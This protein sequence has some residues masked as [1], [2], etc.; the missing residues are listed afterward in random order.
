MRAIDFAKEVGIGRRRLARELGVSEWRA[1]R[2]LEG[3][4]Y[5]DISY[6]EIS[7][8]IRRLGYKEARRV[9]VPREVVKNYGFGMIAKQIKLYKG[10]AQVIAEKYGKSLRKIFEGWR[11]YKPSPGEVQTWGYV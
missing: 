1:R 6:K 10:T 3:R 4:R 8:A 7:K 5:P 9:G 2:I 11:N